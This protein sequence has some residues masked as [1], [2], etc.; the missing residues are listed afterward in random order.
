MLVDGGRIFAHYGQRIIRFDLSGALLGAD[1][2]SDQRDYRW[3]LVA[4]D[5]LPLVSRLKREQVVL[6]G[7]A[8]RQ[9][10]HV[11]RLYSLSENCK[12]M[13]EAVQLPPLPERVRHA[14][15]IDGWLL[16]AT[17]SSTLAVAC[18]WAE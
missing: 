11:Y 6:A 3:L 17:P 13:G 12:L 10:K 1:I 9:T 2:V 14:S 7:Q 18:P 15:V 16:L 5:R 4:E 8:G